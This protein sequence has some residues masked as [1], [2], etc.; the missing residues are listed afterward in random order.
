MTKESGIWLYGINPVMEAVKAGRLISIIYAYRQRQPN[1]IAI[2]EMAGKA[3]ITIKSAERDFFDA[4]FPKGHQGIA[5]L[6]EQK[7]TLGIVE[8]LNLPAEKKET[9]FFFILDCIED[10]RNFGAILRAADAAA[11]HG[12]V[13]QSA[14][15]AGITTVV[16]KASA[17]AL[18]HINLAEVVNIKHAIDK[19]KEADILIIG[20]EADSRITLWD[21]D[22]TLPIALVL[23]SEGHGLRRTVKERCDSLISLPM[24]G[25]VNSLNVS[26]AA[27]VLSYE[28]LRQRALKRS[29]KTHVS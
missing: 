18:E 5:A 26:V 10:P 4:R 17:G 2:T 7:K 12:V 8:L 27:G 25:K 14:R 28:V 1:I 9:P 11:V 20:A 3:G 29:C 13:F 19:M 15:S 23:G 21:I 24:K 6:V 22:L 16:S